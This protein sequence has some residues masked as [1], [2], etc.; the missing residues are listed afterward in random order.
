MDISNF[1]FIK[2]NDKHITQT[3]I[4][5]SKLA[6][7]AL[8]DSDSL[9]VGAK[10][11]INRYYYIINKIEDDIIE[12]RIEYWRNSDY[13]GIPGWTEKHYIRLKVI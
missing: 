8:L 12:V 5:S 2:D 10:V 9:K 11:K 6:I 7:L 1:V 4:K 13:V 3:E